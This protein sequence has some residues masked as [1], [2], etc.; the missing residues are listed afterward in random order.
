V[1]AA[2]GGSGG[3][4]RWPATTIGSGAADR[5]HR[6]RDA[7]GEACRRAAC[8]RRQAS[9]PRS[10]DP[11]RPG[12]R[13]HSAQG[14][15]GRRMAAHPR[16]ARRRRRRLARASPPEPTA[17]V[18]LDPSHGPRLRDG[19]LPAERTQSRPQGSRTRTSFLEFDESTGRRTKTARQRAHRTPA[20]PRRSKRQ[21]CRPRG[22]CPGRAARVA[23]RRRGAPDLAAKRQPREGR[24]SVLLP[25]VLARASVRAAANGGLGSRVRPPGQGR[26][27]IR[28]AVRPVGSRGPGTSPIV[29][30]LARSAIRGL[31]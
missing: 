23:G 8:G 16:C 14:I 2:P 1:A 28:A 9:R 6:P 19:A 4:C 26:M 13:A 10:A 5:D 18:V 7:P 15:R 24:Y 17:R 3:V 21:D 25:R 12:A 30:S 22:A 31:T 11:R 27:R 29:T 20:C